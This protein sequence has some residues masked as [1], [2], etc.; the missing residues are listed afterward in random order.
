MS[1]LGKMEISSLMV[2][3]GGEINASFINSG[4]V[5][6]FVCVIA[7]KIIG[8]KNAV[9]WVGGKGIEKMNDSIKLDIHSV[10]KCGTD[11]VITAYPEKNNF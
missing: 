2:E 5:D 11:L 7:P 6:K 3:G 1:E 4:L 9:S 8:G 10:K